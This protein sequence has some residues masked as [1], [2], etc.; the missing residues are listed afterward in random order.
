[1]K[2]WWMRVGICPHNTDF[3]L[4]AWIKLDGETVETIED[5]EYRCY[6]EGIK[7]SPRN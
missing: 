7:E 3:T 1:M 6:P 5:V 4:D 2:K